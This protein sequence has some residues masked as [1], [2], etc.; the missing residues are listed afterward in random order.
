MWPLT[1]FTIGFRGLMVIHK[2]ESE[3]P[4]YFEIGVLDDPNHA[5]TLNTIKNGMLAETTLLPRPDP[6]DVR[7]RNAPGR[8][9]S[10]AVAKSRES[11]RAVA[12]VNGSD[13]RLAARRGAVERA[14]RRSGITE[15]GPPLPHDT[16]YV[17]PEAAP[18]SRR[19]L[20]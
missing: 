4:N 11:T 19:S 17:G 20:P 14:A 5:L 1:T 8:K 12:G 13:G 6:D 9:P 15:T 10:T 2:V 18:R 16:G 7:R 3:E